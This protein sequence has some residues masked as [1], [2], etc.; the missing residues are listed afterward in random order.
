MKLYTKKEIALRYRVSQRTIENWAGLILPFIKIGG[1]LL[2][3]V[4][5][6]DAAVRLFTR[7]PK[8]AAKIPKD[9]AEGV[10]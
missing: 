4:D 5:E 9:A 7:R 1:K 8:L 10:R 6:C 3:D 2:F